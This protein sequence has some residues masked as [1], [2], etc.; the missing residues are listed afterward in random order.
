MKFHDAMRKVF[1]QFSLVVLQDDRLVTLLSGYHA[2][3]SRPGIRQ[4]MESIASDGYGRELYRRRLDGGSAIRDYA[5]E[6]RQAL[7]SDRHFSRELSGYAVDSVLYAIGLLDSVEEPSF[8]VHAS[9]ETENAAGSH[10]EIS[11]LPAA[12]ERPE[13]QGLNVPGVTAHGSAGI[14]AG[15]TAA[16]DEH[17]AGGKDLSENTVSQD[18]GD[19]AQ[20][21]QSAAEL[22]DAAAQCSLARMYEEGK[23][24]RQDDSSALRWYRKSAFQGNPD[25]QYR[26]GRMYEEGKGISRDYSFAIRWYRKAAGQGNSDAEYSLGMMYEKGQ[27]VGQDN[28]QAAR[29]YSVSADHGNPDAKERLKERKWDLLVRASLKNDPDT[30]YELG[31]MCLDSSG[32]GHDEEEAARWFLKAAEQGNIS[33]QYS[34]G[35]MYYHGT[36]VTQDE[37]EALKWYQKAAEQGSADAQKDLGDIYRRRYTF[38]D[39]GSKAREWYRKA[40]EQGNA[41]ALIMLGIMCENGEGAAENYSEAAEWYRKAAEQGDAKAQCRL[42]DLYMSGKGVGLDYEEAVRWY[43]KAVSKEGTEFLSG[44]E[45]LL[46]MAVIR[47]DPDAMSNL[48]EHFR[49]GKVVRQDYAEARKWHLK[50]IEQ[51]NVDSMRS[52]GWMYLNGEGVAQDYAEGLKWFRK[53]ADLGDSLAQES[54]GKIYDAGQ[55]VSRDY[56]EAFIWYSKAAAGGSW[57]AKAK[58]KEPIFELYFKAIRQ[59][60]ANAQL[61]LAEQYIGHDDWHFRHYSPEESDR[62]FRMAVDNGS[63][64]APL[65]LGDKCY[66]HSKLVEAVKWYRMA[67]MRGSKAAQLKLGR[68]FMS[69]RF[70]G[71]ARDYAEARKWYLMAAEQAGQTRREWQEGQ[72]DAEAAFCLGRIYAEGLGVDPDYAEAWKWFSRL[73]RD[74][75]L[76][77]QEK[78]LLIEFVNKLRQSTDAVA[79]FILGEMFRIRTP[80]VFLRA[81]EAVECYRKAAERGHAEAQFQL[82][83]M[84]QSGMNYPRDYAEAARWFS[85]AARQGHMEAKKRL[86]EPPISVYYKAGLGDAAAEYSLGRMYEEGHDAVLDYHKAAEWY[87]K[88]ADLGNADAMYRLGRMRD[89]GIG[90][91]QNKSEALEWYRKAAALGNADARNLLG[92]W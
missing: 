78:R 30:Q 65:K 39:Y 47:N 12:G 19:P 14:P 28:E 91:S 64:E 46:Y 71:I 7:V 61:R 10:A 4:V 72:D 42:G 43:V 58:L 40:A 6:V 92:S 84:L 24:A 56:A 3:D 8:A 41:E 26:L 76:P 44:D 9:R 25:A 38:R 75:D 36:G 2:F 1:R 48:A 88:S 70:R 60:D 63:A 11:H 21:I 37:A 18:N 33:A 54:L 27:G 31:R 85:E 29:W 17:M 83:C 81:E 57:T 45:E 66:N 79:Q 87:R 74:Y 49:D 86:D 82:G 77:D 59:N 73:T 50:A 5:G 20:G 34:L 90:M 51:G 62:F 15:K 23:G 52:L 67:A 35:Q 69:D 16:Q 22:G 89:D 80:V 13:Q 68:I 53:A 32:A 55:I